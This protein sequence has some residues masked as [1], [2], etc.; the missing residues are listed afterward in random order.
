MIARLLPLVGTSLL[1]ALVAMLGLKVFQNIR[2]KPVQNTVSVPVPQN[3]PASSSAT[4]PVT[5]RPAVYYAAITERPLFDPTRRPYAP[6]QVA[7]EPEVDEVPK[8]PT[9]EP[10]QET[11]PPSI[12]LQGIMTRD[13]KKAALIGINDGDSVWVLQG[14]PVADW[15]LSNIGNDWIEISRDA[16]NIRVD[17]YK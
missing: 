7:V 11:P 10:E 4:A 16:R 17:M 1:I 9:P 8:A 12:S 3:I 14:D 15:T 6:E 5:N 2:T 13:N